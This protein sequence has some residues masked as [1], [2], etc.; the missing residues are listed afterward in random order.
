[1]ARGLAISV[2]ALKPAKQVLSAD[3]M[4][5]ENP[6]RDAQ[7][8]RYTLRDPLITEMLHTAR[9][10]F[11]NHLVATFKQFEL[12]VTV[13]D[14]EQPEGGTELPARRRKRRYHGPVSLVCE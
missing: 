1:M 11:D 12:L 10:I 4:V 3:Q 6:P 13:V 8:I 14:L 9:T 5:V 7:E 2:F